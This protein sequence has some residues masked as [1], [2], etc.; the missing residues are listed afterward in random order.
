M[1][2]PAL[3]IFTPTYNRAHTLPRLFES[4]QRQTCKDFE[5]LVIDDGSSDNTS[6]LFQVWLMGDCEFRIRYVPV[7]NGGKNRAINQALKLARGQYFMILDSDDILPKDSIEFI[8]NKFREVFNLHKFIGISGRKADIYTK[9]PLG[10]EKSG[11]SEEGFVDCNNLE[12]SKYG[13]ERDMAEVFIT[14]KLRKYEFKVWPNEKF[15]PEEVVWNQMAL[16]GY[17]LRWYN[18]VT[19]L[20]EYQE[21]GLTNSSWRLLRDNPMGYA[22]MWNHKLLYLKSFKNILNAVVQYGS[23]CILAKEWNEIFKCNRKLMSITLF[24]MSFTTAL[25]RK[26]QIKKFT[27]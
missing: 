13:L 12:R 14:D 27:N 6:E 19:Y 3:T 10:T 8:L 24:P 25:R 20:C 15:T 18:K 9:I 5:W 2:N 17:K 4:L 7:V 23:C 11:W 21:G 26:H 16:D 1:S 22:M